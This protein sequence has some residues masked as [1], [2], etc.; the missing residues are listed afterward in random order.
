ME[1]G[2]GVGGYKKRG[3]T[4]WVLPLFI[5]FCLWLFDYFANKSGGGYFGDA[6]HDEIADFV[7]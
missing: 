4:G 3:K 6:Y 2:M 7:S 1:W 5:V